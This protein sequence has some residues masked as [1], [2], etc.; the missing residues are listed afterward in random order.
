MLDII[1]KRS[2]IEARY[3]AIDVVFR[4]DA[5][6]LCNRDYIT[7]STA[8]T[9]LACNVLSY[10]RD[11]VPLYLG[12]TR[13]FKFLQIDAQGAEVGFMFLKSFFIQDM[14]EIENDERFIGL[15]YKHPEPTGKDVHDNLEH[16]GFQSSI[17]VY[18][19]LGKLVRVKK[20]IKAKRY[21]LILNQILKEQI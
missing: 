6:H 21:Y 18:T 3:W 14:T 2:G 9:K 10:I 11:I 4:Q 1:L 15:F 5:L 8:Y 13:S 17:T 19:L 16:N 20:K 7:N 12:K